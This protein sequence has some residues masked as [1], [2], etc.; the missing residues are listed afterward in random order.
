MK[1][2][3][4]S[5]AYRF[6]DLS[7]PELIKQVADAGY[8]G[9]EL[10]YPH[11]IRCSKN[12]LQDALQK[13]NIEACMISPYLNL[14]GSPAQWKKSILIAEDTINRAK[15]LG[16]HFLRCFTGRL[17]SNHAEAKHWKDAVSG[18]QIIADL[19]K[20]QNI[21]VA[22][23]THPNTLADSYEAI[24]QLLA[25]VN[26]DNVGIIF[27]FYNLWEI[28]H[29]K[30]YEYF[31]NLYPKTYH[32]HLKN[33]KTGSLQE[34]PFPLV[35]NKDANLDN[36]CYLKDGDINYTQIWNYLVS[37]CFNGYLS[38]EWFGRDIEAA[39]IHERKYLIKEVTR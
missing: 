33:A 27:D 36:I 29:D 20:A 17:G 10:W 19:A 28:E 4:C 3:F 32:L 24:C 18:I 21:S 35:L 5:I 12:E 16:C 37:N 8:D 13:N 34:S 39:A 11:V 9:I 30:I 22:I 6:S 23:E 31:E 38:V 15:Q 26:K 7:T 1:L 2:S 25:E 14:T